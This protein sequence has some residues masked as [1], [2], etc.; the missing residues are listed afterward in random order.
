[1]IK[2]AP[3]PRRSQ[4]AD[5]PRQFATK[6]GNCQSRNKA[7]IHAG[8]LVSISEIHPL[9]SLKTLFLDWCDAESYQ[10]VERYQRYAEIQNFLVKPISST[11]TVD[12]EVAAQHEIRK[13]L[14]AIITNC[15]D[16]TAWRL[17]G[18]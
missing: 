11:T 16:C 3:W 12:K 2:A 17:L 7:A 18:H 9:D 15:G 4:P 8:L 6:S 14:K 5:G 10:L 13:S 1:V